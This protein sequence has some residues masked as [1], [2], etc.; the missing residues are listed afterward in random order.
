MYNLH[1]HAERVH[2][3]RDIGMLHALTRKQWRTSLAGKPFKLPHM[4]ERST[5]E[6]LTS[7]P[8]SSSRCCISRSSARTWSR[9][10]TTWMGHT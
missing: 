6:P 1:C 3:A 7:S 2:S 10:Y 4:I 8:A 5:Y 9:M